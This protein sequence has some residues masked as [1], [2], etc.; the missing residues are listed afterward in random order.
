[1]MP[2]IV[3]ALREALAQDDGTLAEAIQAE[4]DEM[5]DFSEVEPRPFI[6][7]EGD[8][9]ILDANDLGEECLAARVHNGHLE[10][11]DR[12]SRQW[13]LVTQKRRTLGHVVE[14]KGKK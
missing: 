1:M 6:I 7:S 11:L 13:E 2:D 9:Y 8:Y 4:L 3:K 10:T 5:F 12:D 14:I